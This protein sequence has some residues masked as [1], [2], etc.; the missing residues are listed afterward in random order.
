MLAAT[1][2]CG[3]GSKYGGKLLAEAAEHAV[4][5]VLKARAAGKIAGL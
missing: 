5:V 4:K 2:A 1:K 3:D